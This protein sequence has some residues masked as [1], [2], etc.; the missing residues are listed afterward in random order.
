[1]WVVWVWVS[2]A[3]VVERYG[4]GRGMELVVFLVWGV[5]YWRVEG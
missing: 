1:M 5:E 4:K 2:M 3:M